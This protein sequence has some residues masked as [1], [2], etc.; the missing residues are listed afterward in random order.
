M[1]SNSEQESSFKTIKLIPNRSISVLFFWI[2]VSVVIMFHALLRPMIN[3]FVDV[4]DSRKAA[5]IFLVLS[6]AGF[7]CG[8][9]LNVAVELT[10]SD[11][12]IENRTIFF[13]RRW[14]LAYS[15]LK[16]VRWNA[17]SH[18]ISLETNLGKKYQLPSI[19]ILEHG[20]L[21][22]CKDREGAPA[23]SMYQTVFDLY[24]ELL[25]RKNSSQVLH[26][27]V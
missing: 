9:G 17:Y 23:S 27:V 20:L 26:E 7:C 25:N 5:M 21:K 2:A 14:K 11:L 10:D 6:F 19:L 8:Y 18:S 12:I 4:A 13:K 3:S 1:A 15:D 22:N 16:V 24:C